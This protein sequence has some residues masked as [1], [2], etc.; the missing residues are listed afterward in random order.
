MSGERYGITELRLRKQYLQY[1]VFRCN[2][3]AT[4]SVVACVHMLSYFDLNGDYVTNMR[5]IA[6]LMSCSYSVYC[7]DIASRV[8]FPHNAAVLPYIMQN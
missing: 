7:P 3:R 6:T 5:A 4:G 8:L 1:P 2:C